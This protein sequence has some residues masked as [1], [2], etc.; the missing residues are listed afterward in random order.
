MVSTMLLKGQAPGDYYCYQR[1]KVQAPRGCYSLVGLAV[2]SWH[3]RSLWAL[4]GA[5]P[6]MDRT[7][8]PGSL[9]Q[10]LLV[11]TDSSASHLMDKPEESSREIRVHGCGQLCIS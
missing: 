2:G 10:H 5:L 9:S 11:G 3:R 6:L 1:K 8:E 4:L 7:L